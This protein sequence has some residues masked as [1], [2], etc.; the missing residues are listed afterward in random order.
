MRESMKHLK[1]KEQDYES[2]SP[3]SWLVNVKGE[4]KE[5]KQERESARERKTF[6]SLLMRATVVFINNKKKTSG[7]INPIT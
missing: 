1:M 7:R 6:L 2:F 4:K 3:F 5:N